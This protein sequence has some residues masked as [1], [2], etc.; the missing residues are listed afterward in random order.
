MEEIEDDIRGFFVR[1][2][3]NDRFRIVLD[4]IIGAGSRIHRSRDI[5]KHG[6]DGLLDGIHINIAHDDDGL[7][8]GTIPLVVIS[9]QFIRFEIV[10]HLNRANRHPVGIAAGGHHLRQLL[11]HDTEAGIATGTPFFADDTTFLLDHRVGKG[12]EVR[13]I[14]QNQ[15]A[16]IDHGLTGDRGVDN[17]IDRFV[18]AGISV[19]VL[20]HTHTDAL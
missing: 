14:M 20:A 1:D 11:L 16:A 18:E 6:F 2:D 15:E 5:G 12:Q 4:G 19:Q 7:Q 9:P 3:G 8:V 13:P 10:N 17:R